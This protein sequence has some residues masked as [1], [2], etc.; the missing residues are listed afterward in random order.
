[1]SL[2]IALLWFL[3]RQCLPV[4]LAAALMAL[5]YALHWTEVLR[6]R[7]PAPAVFILIHSLA[8]TG[9]QGRFATAGFGFLYTRGYSRGCL[10]AHTMLASLLCVLAVWLP[11]AVII[12]SP[13]RGAVQDHL[14]QS[15]YFPVMAPLEA[16]VPL[17]WLVG[18][19][20]LILP[21]HY[22]WIRSAQPTRGG[23]GGN[24]TAAGLCVAIFTVVVL[25][26]RPRWYWWLVYAACAVVILTTLIAGRKLHQSLEVRG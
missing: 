5:P 14:H 24:L 3:F 22:A 13:A 9:F 19:V 10:W 18:Y 2:R 4:T 12:W 20:L 23:Q 25:N 1:M 7:D 11:A 15:P 26:P 16:P 8:L 21:F 6:W 17:I